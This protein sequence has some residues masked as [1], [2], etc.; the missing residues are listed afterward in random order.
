MDFI[1]GA[2]ATVV[3]LVSLFCAA[4]MDVRRGF[5]VDWIWILSLIATPIALV[6]LFTSGFLV[7]YLLQALITLVFV[8]LTFHLGVLGGA[9]GKAVIILSIIYPWPEIN[10]VML[11]LSPIL[12]VI[13]GF[14]IVGIQC[15]ILGLSNF[16]NWLKS[17]E[18][19]RTNLSPK[20][21]RFWL[22]RRLSRT[23]INNE[24]PWKTVTVPLILYFLLTYLVLLILMILF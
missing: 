24:E 19:I 18:E 17:A 15:T 16:F 10:Q 1:L 9:D 21:Q 22:T 20:K 23:S 14:S 3:F 7:L 8:L 6:R 12:V 11:L 13:G 2:I 5:V 4:I